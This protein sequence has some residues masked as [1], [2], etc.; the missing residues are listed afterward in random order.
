MAEGLDELNRLFTSPDPG[1]VIKFYDH[2]D[3]AEQLIEWMKN[4]PSAPMEI[5]E[6]EGEKDIVFVIPTADHN[7]ELANN[8]K[9]I[10][11]GQQI[12]FVESS[13]PFFNYA[14]SCNFGL[15]YALKY[16]PKW[17]VLSND[18]EYKIDDISILKNKLSGIN[19][20]DM[21]LV[22][23]DKWVLLKERKFINLYRFLREQSIFSKLNKKFNASFSSMSILRFNRPVY[24]LFFKKIKEFHFFGAFVIFNIDYLQKK[25][26][27]FDENFINGY[28]DV[29]LCY[30]D[31]DK[32]NMKIIEFKIGG[33]GAK[34]LGGGEM[35]R[36]H[37][38]SSRVYFNHLLKNQV[39]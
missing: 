4:R 14:R 37:S 35:R 32:H 34:S 25:E 8:C 2:F 3:T 23:S 13:G 21:V 12:I 29:F 26:H 11:R 24:K 36:L 22:N 16:K 38:F 7:G 19:N 9:E 15:K 39:F 28:E 27:V 31:S 20:T 6:V 18:D 10:F 1:D 17:V 33:Y 5:F 30:K